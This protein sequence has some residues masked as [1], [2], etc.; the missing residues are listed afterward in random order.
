MNDTVPRIEYDRIMTQ[1]NQVQS[2]NDA[3]RLDVA[4]LRSQLAPQAQRSSVSQNFASQQSAQRDSQS[5]DS[6]CERTTTERPAQ[7]V[8]VHEHSAS[9]AYYMRAVLEQAPNAILYM[10]DGATQHALWAVMSRT[11]SAHLINVAQRLWDIHW[12]NKPVA[13][14]FSSCSMRDTYCRKK[15]HLHIIFV[16]DHAP[17]INTN[18]D[19]PSSSNTR[20]S[21]WET[22]SAGTALQLFSWGSTHLSTRATT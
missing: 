22:T 16:R 6:A 18:L 13:R 15:C 5:S 10:L 17:R 7:R 8:C 12:A 11:L 20:V 14:W 4:Q 9:L 19:Y 21:C 3:M 2:E 1:R